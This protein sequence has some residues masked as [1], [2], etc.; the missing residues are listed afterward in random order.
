MPATWQELSAALSGLWVYTTRRDMIQPP[1]PETYTA[2][3]PDAPHIG[4][5][6]QAKRQGVHN[7]TVKRE[8]VMNKKTCA[9]ALLIL[10]SLASATAP[11]LA[12]ADDIDLGFKAAF[13]RPIHKKKSFGLLVTGTTIVAAGTFTYFT[14]GAGAPPAAAGVS[15]VASW[16][17]G[18]GAG[19]YMAGASIVGGWF[20]GNAMLGAA[21]LN[22]ISL[23]TV[24]AAGSWGA[25]NAG[26][27]V[28]ALGS[29]AATIMDGIAFVSKPGTQQL[30][31]R[32]ILPVPADFAD[33]RTREIL[34]AV[35]KA[36]EDISE[37]AEE[38]E[39]ARAEQLPG[40]PKS[41]KVL[42][43]ERALE[44]AKARH[45][46]ATMQLNDE[47]DRV[48]KAGA[49]NRTT[50]LMAV[51]AHNSG[52]SADFR[53]LLGRIK[54]D[55][56]KDASYLEYLRAIADLQLGKVNDAERRLQ[57]SRKAASFAVEPAI[58]L[59]GLAGSRGFQ[60][61]ESKID[62]I[63]AFAEKNF[64]SDK[65]MTPANL[66]SLYYRIG[67]MALAA[68]R[69]ERAHSAFKKAQDKHSLL[70]KYWTGKDIR[71]FLDIGE[72]NALHCQGKRDEAFAI[73]NAV[74]QRTTGKEAR[75]ML[76]IQYS[77]GCRT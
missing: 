48:L 13:H 68:N 73:F 62:E 57:A 8:A 36:S 63:A 28:L 55:R 75:D 65:Y 51:I 59:A 23:G 45:K 3:K 5:N 37:G 7:N 71:N 66:V 12:A 46:T 24:G 9:L 50:T 32:V 56:L 76:C 34:N 33:D 20:G 60:S 2:V 27:K 69:C 72:A 70:S 40:S 58:L 64:K 49:S 42:E 17:A 26:Q 52:R 31:W 54:A 22:G 16:V 15:T 44:A 4:E 18:G 29:T 10:A 53:N 14:A 19:S 47:L 38:L 21:V 39:S 74:W 43:A 67:T 6:E 1:S 41:T 25:L 35:R 30:E 61:Q 11:V 77:G